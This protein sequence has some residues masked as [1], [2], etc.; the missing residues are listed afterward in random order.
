MVTSIHKLMMLLWKIHSGRD[1]LNTTYENKLFK[2]L[3]NQKY[4]SAIFFLLDIYIL[5]EDKK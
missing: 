2:M 1:S 3:L 5:A 4:M